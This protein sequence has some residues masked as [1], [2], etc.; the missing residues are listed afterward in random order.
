MDKIQDYNQIFT[1]LL[2]LVAVLGGTLFLLFYMR[3]RRRQRDQE[4]ERLK[5]DAVKAIKLQEFEEKKMREQR[6]F[7]M[8]K[9]YEERD[10]NDRRQREINKDFLNNLKKEVEDEIS[11]INT[12]GY[13]ILDLPDNMRSMFSDLLKGF[14]EFA[15]LKGY[16][17]SF[18]VDTSI[19]NKIAFKF[20]L[21]GGGI[22]VSTQTVR[23]DIKDYIEKVKK[24]ETFDDLPIIISPE[25]HSLVSTTLKNRI[26]FLQHNYN[27]EKNTREYYENLFKKLSSSANG[28]GQQPSIFIQ[29]GG[30]NTPKHLIANNSQ[31]VL[32]GED[33]L[34]ENSSDN[35][36]H[37][38]ITISNSF[39][40][41][42]EQV[43]KLD[44]LINLIKQ[45][46]EINE[47][48]KQSLIT[49]FDKIKEEITDEDNPN[50]SRLF[51]WFSNT[52]KIVENVVLT[53]HTTEAIHWIYENFNF[54]IHH[55]PK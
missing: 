16:N 17:I 52:K 3:D 38:Q 46:K 39:N 26:N 12:G 34:Y 32:L 22:N 13:I 25:E 23:Q 29:T 11:G 21:L 53:H 1:L 54:L 51:K 9:L 33:V 10:I 28:L 18:S 48:E 35:S 30:V 24:E 15:K 19:P 14:E 36:D 55:L 27:L 20:T 45:E 7:E 49:N 4:E 6:E 5:V 40:K 41:R 43:A 8:H 37:S 42:K 31:N 44:E 47:D 50:K 2:L